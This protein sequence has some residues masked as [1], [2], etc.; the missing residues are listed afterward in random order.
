M[1]DEFVAKVTQKIGKM[2]VLTQ[3]ITIMRVSGGVGAS[4]AMLK[5]LKISIKGFLTIK[6][7]KK[8]QIF[9]GD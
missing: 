9:F 6:T 5:V 1:T 7:G 2:G 3:F 8:R 4:V